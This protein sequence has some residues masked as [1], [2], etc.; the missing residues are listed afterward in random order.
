MSEMQNKPVNDKNMIYCMYCGFRYSKKVKRC[1][2]CGKKHTQPCYHKFWFWII[3]L[4][5]VIIIFTPSDE[6]YNSESE[7]KEPVISETEYKAICSSV[8][9]EDIA[10]KPNE[11]MGE[12]VVFSGKV[13]QV[14]EEGKDVMLR[15]N[16]T[17]GEFGIW[18]DTI[19]VE[20]RRKSDNESRIL[21]DDI[22]TLYGEIQGI[23]NYTAIL[24]NQVSVPHLKAEYIELN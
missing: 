13:I 2:Q 21:E 23:K 17:E 11:Y 1:P 8:S 18:D 5:M 15:V 22:V 14:L 10:R 16:V 20:Y 9:Y 4:L 12:T 7:N 6:S 3:A 19:Y 24:G